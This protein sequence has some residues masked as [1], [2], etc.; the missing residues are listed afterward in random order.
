M[1]DIE[2]RDVRCEDCVF[3][4]VYEDRS[5]D[6]RHPSCW[7]SKDHE[8]IQ[9]GFMEWIPELQCSDYQKGEAQYL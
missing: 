9:I 2:D 1:N 7:C 6:M 3:A 4:N 8:I 5:E